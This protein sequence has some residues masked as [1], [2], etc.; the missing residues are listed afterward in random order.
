M[1]RIFAAADFQS[2][3]SAA[4]FD[5]SAPVPAFV[6][7]ATSPRAEAGFAV[8]RNNVIAGLIR[9]VGRRFPVVRRLAGEDSFDAVAHRYVVARP[10]RSPML[11]D[12]GD[13]FPEYVR[14][15]GHEAMFE[16]LADV[17]EL[18][19]LRGRA[20]HAADADPVTPE[21]FAVL[22]DRLDHVYVQLHPS[23]FLLRSRFPIV[24]IWQSNLEDPG[25]SATLDRWVP[26]CAL[27][28]RPFLDVQTWRLSAGAYAFIDTLRRS[29]SLSEAAE[30]GFVADPGFDLAGALALV[31]ESN[32]VVGLTA[33][34]LV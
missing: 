16:Y 18:E 12:Y 4:L 19:W 9:A 27:V 22:A 29:A 26:E 28:V 33:P 8:Y 24:T 34:T 17:A 14:G 21:A 32:A 2:G 10:P 7:A 15:L 23:A 5:P 20:Y 3:F 31:I 30:A 11:I 25:G 1:T 6:L 13:D